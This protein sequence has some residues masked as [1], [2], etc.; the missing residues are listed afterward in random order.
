M[1]ILY[2]ALLRQRTGIGEE[3]VVL[4]PEVSDVAALIE[5]LKH[6]GPNFAE[7]LADTSAIRVAVDQEFAVAADGVDAAQPL[8]LGQVGG[9]GAQQ[10]GLAQAPAFDPPQPPRCDRRQDASLARDRGRQ[11]DIEGADPI[12]RDD[13]QAGA[14][15]PIARAN[16]G[17][18]VQISDFSAPRGR[19]IQIGVKDHRGH[20]RARIRWSVG[21]GCIVSQGD[22]PGGPRL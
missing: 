3:D 17:Q 14:F 7:A 11:D 9:V 6:R 15:G 10:V 20:S 13:H 21:H 1:K 18:I 5:W 4:P 19:K 2:F 8:G 22:R 16:G 12:G